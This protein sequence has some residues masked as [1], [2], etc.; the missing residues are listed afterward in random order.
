MLEALA[1]IDIDA[2][3][4]AFLLIVTTVSTIIAA[5]N[6]N[7]ATTA[8]A[9]KEQAQA[10]TNNVQ[11][12]FDPNDTTVMTA[13][14]GTPTAS[15]TMSDAVKNFLTDG[16]SAE[17]KASILD[18]VLKAEQAGYVDYKIHYSRGTYLISYGQISGGSKN[19]N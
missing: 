4:K 14:A 19:N 8:T 16:E 11:K 7:K 9:E 6:G 12:F 2:L 17:D 5:L 10:E 18:Q 1:S 3:V 15:Y 13:P